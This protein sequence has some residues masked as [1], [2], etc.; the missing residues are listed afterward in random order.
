MPAKLLS[1]SFLTLALPW[2]SLSRRPFLFLS[3]C[4]CSACVQFF[5]LF[6]LLPLSHFFLP[7][8]PVFPAR[9][10]CHLCPLRAVLFRSVSSRRGARSAFHMVQHNIKLLLQKSQTLCFLTPHIFERIFIDFFY[11]PQTPADLIRS[12]FS[13]AELCPH[14]TMSQWRQRLCSSF[15]SLQ[16]QLRGHAVTTDKFTRYTTIIINIKSLKGGVI[17]IRS[18]MLQY[19]SSNYV[20]AFSCGTSGPH[21]P[22]CFTSQLPLDGKPSNLY[23]RVLWIWF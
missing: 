12:C 23:S 9:Y 7:H 8:L 13:A 17:K 3:V 19:V 18:W 4:C 1:S 20:L 2:L 14:R 11:S 5:L 16:S 15:S 22:R 21:A 10:R 6:R